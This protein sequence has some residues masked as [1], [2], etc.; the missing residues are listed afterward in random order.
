[1]DTEYEVTAVRELNSRQRLVYINDEPAFALYKS[2]LEHYALCEAYAV[3]AEDYAEIVNM[4]SKRAAARAMNLLKGRDYAEKEL[5]RKLKASYYP[6]E[7]VDYA[8]CYV[9]QFGY[10]DDMRYASSYVA[11][12]AQ[13]K[14]RRQIEAF[15]QNKGIDRHIIEQACTGYY[16]D[17]E[18]AE[19]KQV[20]RLMEKKLSGADP[21]G[22]DYMQ[23]QRLLAA[24]CRKGFSA[25]TVEK[26]MDMIKGR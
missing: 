13:S 9:K 10:V 23:R 17:D 15:L 14:S 22:L 2:E 11:F 19:L 7:S 12:K 8:L 24:F 21:D 1:M 25:E 4:L 6:E 18:D 26:A 3:P 16:E 5:R 20:V